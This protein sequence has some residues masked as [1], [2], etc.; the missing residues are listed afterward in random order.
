V[1][2]QTHLSK[3]IQRVIKTFTAGVL[4]CKSGQKMLEYVWLQKAVRDTED[5]S[6]M[7]FVHVSSCYPVTFYL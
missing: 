5:Q 6:G 7:E 2:P 3:T 1:S 4:R